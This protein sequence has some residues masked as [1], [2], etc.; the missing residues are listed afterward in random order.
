MEAVMCH[1]FTVPK[2]VNFAGPIWSIPCTG[3]VAGVPGAAKYEPERQ[4]VAT[5][6]TM[7][8]LVVLVL[9]ILAA[10]TAVAYARTDIAA[11]MTAVVFHTSQTDEP[12]A[13]LLSGSA[14][15]GLAGALRRFAF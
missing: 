6:G 7:K 10:A 15:I 9:V 13:L 12:I 11:G 1:E 14:L 3:E 4:Q 8:A 5:V 2:L